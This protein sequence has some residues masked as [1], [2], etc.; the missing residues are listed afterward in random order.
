MCGKEQGQCRI[1][2]LWKHLESAHQGWPF[3]WDWGLVG[4]LIHWWTGSPCMHFHAWMESGSGVLLIFLSAFYDVTLWKTSQH[5]DWPFIKPLMADGNHVLSAS[6]AAY[7]LCRLMS[8]L[9][10]HYKSSS[11]LQQEN[12]NLTLSLIGQTYLHFWYQLFVG[13]KE[14]RSPKQNDTSPNPP[15][16]CTILRS[17]QL[18]NE[19]PSLLM[20]ANVLA[21]DRYGD[22]CVLSTCHLS[23]NL[24]YSTWFTKHYPASLHE[25]IFIFLK[26]IRSNISRHNKT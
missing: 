6:S 3:Y 24:Q 9:W 11:A 4:F 10:A 13:G 19:M 23:L 14:N 22:C 15:S 5:G 25:D 7:Q 12:F 16:Y 17:H 2:M 18:K 26:E 21:F 20:S 8:V 1:L